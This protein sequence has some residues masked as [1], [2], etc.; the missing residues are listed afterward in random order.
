[1]TVRLLDR[2]L[3][4]EFSL[5][6]LYA[7]DAFVLLWIVEDLFGT[8]DEFVDYHLPLGQIL[9]YYLTSFPD[10]LIQ[11]I[12]MSLLLGLLFCLSN[13]G[14]HNELLAMRAGGV[15]R[16]RLAVPLLGVGLAATL[17]AL[18]VN[19]L[20]VPRA[21]EHSRAL[22]RGFSGKGEPN[23]VPNLFFVDLRQH[24]DWY[25]LSYNHET[26]V[27]E[28]PEIHERTAGGEPVRDIY[29]ERA[30]W[31]NDQWVFFNAETH[32][33]TPAGHV[34]IHRAAQTNFPS[35]T[36]R[37][38]QLLLQ[39]KRVD[40]MNSGDLRRIIRAHRRAGRTGQLAEYQV[41]LHYRYAFPLTCLVVVWIGVPLGMQIRR[42]GALLSVGVAIGL[43]AGFYFLSNVTLALGGA[44]QINP[45]LAAWL[46]NILFAVIGAALFIRLH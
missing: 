3:L 14:R 5:P 18:A 44:G 12:P 1:M 43:V 9:R 25:A 28:N 36:D 8:L 7:L 6:W 45:I 26:L 31:L 32:E 33:Q 21:R 46:A 30:R 29:A 22:R 42:S 38:R 17:L 13:L 24:R 19:E 4:R 37:P 20:F 10:A 16:A 35:L 11:I 15:S 40:E 2:Y 23:V 27:L 39:N 41:T 34:V